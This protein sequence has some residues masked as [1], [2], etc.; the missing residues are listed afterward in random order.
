M[1]NVTLA[2][3][4][5]TP[6]DPL[7]IELVQAIETP[8]AILIRWPAAPTVTDAR[9]PP[10]VAAAITAILAEARATLAKIRATEL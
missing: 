6:A 3:G 4:Q 5:I 10:A 2:S 1:P 7:T 9:K 8:E